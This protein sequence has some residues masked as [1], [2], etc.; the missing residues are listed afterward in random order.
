MGEPSWEPGALREMG[1]DGG[2]IMWPRPPPPGS[3]RPA[4]T[5]ATAAWWA[6]AC[7]WPLPR[8]EFGLLCILECLWRVSVGAGWQ[9]G[10]VV[11]H[12][13]SVRLSE[14]IVLCSRGKCRHGASLRCG[15]GYGESG[16]PDG[17]RP[18]RR[19]GT[20]RAWGDPVAAHPAARRSA[21]EAP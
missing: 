6:A 5:A 18:C 4:W 17:G 16:A 21:A 7:D 13:G 19:A 9:V 15:C 10:T 1:L 20:C 2:G 12:T 11:Q 14:K 8:R 3:M